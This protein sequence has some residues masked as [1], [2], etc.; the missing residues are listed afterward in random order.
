MRTVIWEDRNG[1]TRASL[2]RDGDPDE[3]AE[4]G[5]PVDPPNLD[6]IDFGEVKRDLH[7][8]LVRRGLFTHKDVQKAGR[9]VTA[10]VVTVLKRRVVNLYKQDGGKTNE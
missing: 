3:A 9:G 4:H 6:R 10:A 5:I 2:I 1:Y 7:N 8:E